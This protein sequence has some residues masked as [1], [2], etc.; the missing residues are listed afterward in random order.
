MA[1]ASES[2]GTEAWLATPEAA[3]RVDPSRLVGRDREE[4]STLQTARRRRDWAS[5]RALLSAAAVASDQTSSL[6][7]THGYAALTL[8]PRAVAV[9]VD[10][11]WLAPRDF[12]GM[13]SV[14]YCAAECALLASL[15]DPQELCAT[16]YELWT[17]KEAFAKALQL[18][19]V[20]ALKQCRFVDAGLDRRADVPT[21][22]HWRAMVFAPRP[23]LRLAV[24]LI[25]DAPEQL[26]APIGTFEWPQARHC[27]WA[28]TRSL[29]GGGS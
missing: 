21:T 6:S 14:A 11:E 8:A 4:W 25:A 27:D 7:H 28:V 22:R 1:G 10:L 26:D 3:D 17:L 23:Q 15:D 5:S 2:R 13:A 20:D 16:F 24:A 18:P 12:R 29:T 19:L 9:G